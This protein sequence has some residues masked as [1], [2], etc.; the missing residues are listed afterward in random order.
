VEQ[1]AI[2]QRLRGQVVDVV[3]RRIFPGEL[4]I[5][6]G[7]ITAV[8][9]L[10]EAPGRFLMPGFVDA[11]VHVE[12]SLLPP[13]EFARLAVARGTLATVSDPHE[14]ANVLGLA[15]VR[16]MLEDAAGVP[17]KFAFGAPSCVPSSPLETAGGRLGPEEVAALLA[18]PGIT[19][20]AEVMDYPAVV[21]GEP[22][23]MAKLAAAHRLHKPVDGHAPGLLGG[24]LAAYVAAGV[25]TD[26][27]CTSLREAQ[28]K[29]E[30]GLKVM[31]RE[32]SAARA[33]TAL[34]PMLEAYPEH[35]MFCC[36]DLH[37][38]D[39]LD[40]HID[41]VVRRAVA[42]GYDLFAVLRAAT[43]NPVRHY[44]LPV[45][46]LQPGDPADI[47]E[48]DDLT[49][50]SVRRVFIDG[51]LAYDHG[52]VT[53]PRAPSR[54]VNRFVGGPR[55]RAD[56]MISAEGAEARVIQV[57]DGELVTHEVR[58]RVHPVAGELR[59]D[60]VRDILKLVV[61][62]RYHDGPSAVALV[63]GFGLRRGALAS[64]VAH[65]AHNVVAVGA[66]E[67]AL[68]AAVNAVVEARGG[69][70]VSADG[71]TDLLPLPIAGLMSD[72]E[73]AECALRYGS[74]EARARIL[75]ARLRAPLMALSFLALPAIPHLKLTDYG[76]VASG[77][78][79][80]PLFV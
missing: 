63:E 30:A 62:P 80:V 14:I 69:L 32:G 49:D 18:E 26:H 29:V 28:A 46:L 36:D 4:E 64:S 23:V 21:A 35:V 8:R 10:A 47:I 55:T 40:G 16:Y 3:A 17:L 38:N 79:L 57:H 43:L 9:A 75:G 5:Q 41:R 50:F 53:F 37:P 56:F 7:R 74:L 31:L 2:P 61:V 20:L 78:G 45:G 44:R 65:D 72:L 1:V 67:E 33:F 19:H 68:V 13:S 39:L 59:A 70:A 11:H 54:P 52:R 71:V 27:E 58:R 22:G 51:V 73:G 42:E 60:P 77:A 24:A 25:S 66:D 34:A 15:G 76:L 48:V 12:S 6:G